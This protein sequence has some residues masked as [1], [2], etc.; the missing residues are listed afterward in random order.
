MKTALLAA[1]FKVL[2]QDQNLLFKGGILPR[3]ASRLH[4]ITELHRLFSRKTTA[5]FS[6][7]IPDQN[8]RHFRPARETIIL[9][10]DN[11]AFFPSA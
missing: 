5:K 8:K 10:D 6:V 4:T 3:S 11:C 2:I 7:L 1:M 9:Y